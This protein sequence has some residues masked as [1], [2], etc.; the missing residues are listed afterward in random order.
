MDGQ[1]QG[2]RDR[3]LTPSN[4]AAMLSTGFKSVTY[5]LR[6]EL[7]IDAW[8]WNPAGAW[9]DPTSKQ[10]YWTSDAG[11]AQP[12]QLSY[13]YKLPRRRRGLKGAACR[14]TPG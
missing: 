11:T 12:I 4:I 8:H 5:R 9:S 14:G 13:G 10:G 1:E 7:A 3:Q 2:D 6:T